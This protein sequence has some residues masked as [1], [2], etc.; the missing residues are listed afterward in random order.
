MGDKNRIVNLYV[1]GIEHRKG[2]GT[3]LLNQFEKLA[4]IKGEKIIKIRSS[5]YAIPFY[6]KRGYK[7]TTGIRCFHRLRFQ[8]MAKLFRETK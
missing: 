8:P 7:K 2:I 3:I 4:K 5:L 6:R 1:K